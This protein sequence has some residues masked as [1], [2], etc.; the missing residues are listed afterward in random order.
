M[1]AFSTVDDLS[2][3]LRERK[4]DYVFSKEA[5]GSFVGLRNSFDTAVRKSG[6]TDFRF[7]D[8]RHTFASKLV[9]EGIDIMTVKELMGHKDLTMTLRYAHLAPNHKTR[10]VT[11]LDRVMSLNPPQMEKASEMVSLRPLN[12]WLGDRDS[13]PNSRSQSPLSYR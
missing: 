2:K 11:I 9:M 5:G 12:H 1:E 13:N 10:A 6:I 4:G 3:M 7:Y 8:L